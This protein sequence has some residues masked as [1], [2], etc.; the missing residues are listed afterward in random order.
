M[1]QNF[2]FFFNLLHHEK[3]RF[4]QTDKNIHITFFIL[5]LARI[6]AKQPHELYLYFE[7]DCALNIFSLSMMS[8]V[9][10]IACRD[11]V[12]TKKHHYCP[13]KVDK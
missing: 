8:V 11:E 13:V 4:L 9:L 3:V 1:E 10:T 2:K 12:Y 6:G 5:L 7:A